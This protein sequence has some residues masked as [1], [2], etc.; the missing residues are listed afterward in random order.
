MATYSALEKLLNSS[1]S[2]RHYRSTLKTCST[3]CLPYLPIILSDL[4]FMEDGNPDTISHMINFQKR[5]L[6]YRVISEVQATQQV[7]YDFPTVEPIHTLLIELPSSSSEELYQ[8]SIQREPRESNNNNPNNNNNINSGGST[9]TASSSTT[10][11]N[12]SNSQQYGTISNHVN[13]HPDMLK[14]L[15]D[16][17]FR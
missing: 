12:L 9:L 13:I 8:L 6:I 10:S 11:S 2:Y 3:P 4:T 7:K 17:D 15:R 14:K 16:K 5:E 1:G